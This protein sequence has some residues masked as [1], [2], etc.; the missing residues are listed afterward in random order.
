L[1]GSTT[2][3]RERW[4]AEAVRLDEDRRGAAFDDPRADHKARDIGGDF[5]KRLV[6]RAGAL[7]AGR[8]YR[9][10]IERLRGPGIA[11][12]VV[13]V[14]MGL[15]AGGGSAAAVFGRDPLVNI[16]WALSLLLG[17]PTLMLLLWT[18]WA[19]LP[20]PQHSG[21]SLTG[22][23]AFGLFRV[24][25][26]R[27]RLG[28]P[29]VSLLSALA[30]LLRS[31]SAGRWSAG[32]LTHALWAAFVLGALIVATWAMAV[33]QYDFVWGTTLLSPEHVVALL[34]ILGAPAQWVGWPVPDPDLI[35]ASRLDVGP[36]GGRESWSTLLLSTLLFF[37]L[38]P[39][40]M[41]LVLASVLASRAFRNIR[42]DTSMPG[43]A[44]LVHR[45]GVQARALGVTDPAPAPGPVEEGRSADRRSRPL[46]GEIVLIG[47]ELERTRAQWPPGLPGVDWRVLGRAD[48]RAQ[49]A[50]VLAGLDASSEATGVV[51]ALCS[52]ARTPDRG[53]L[54]F[55]QRLRATVPSPLW[56]VLE[57]GSRLVSRGIDAPV[58]VQQ[59][60]DLGSAA[61]AD[62]TVE[63]ELDDPEHEGTI[64]L[65]ERLLRV[66]RLP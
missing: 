38:L 60:Q 54:R 14:V 47:F 5:E 44:R 52:L 53:A 13:M 17:F 22:R 21:Q 41:L 7:P 1:S 55:L 35:R 11:L 42:L 3:F 26:R 2:A 8:E 16:G 29:A 36:Y 51:L 46:Y 9:A 25:L 66:E 59:W 4:I 20:I 33:R 24:G 12:L 56:L 15:L 39:R 63:V 28:A 34:S 37:G 31:S 6:I 62:W 19:F 57:E 50:D 27:T 58:R 32:M 18:A 43:Y 23:V 45:V 30:G 49:E 65:R 64:E 48:D 40:V 61:G 10:V